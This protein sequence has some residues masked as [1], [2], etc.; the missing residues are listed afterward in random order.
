MDRPLNG[1]QKMP[2]LQGNAV[3]LSECAP[4]TKR[5]LLRLPGGDAEIFTAGD[6]PPLVLMHPLNIGAGVFAWQF[7]ALADRYRVI[8]VHNPG[9]GATTWNEDMTMNGLAW[10]HRM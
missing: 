9:V 8:C 1:E 2:E 5:D 4:G 7:A 10:F 6:G 3:V